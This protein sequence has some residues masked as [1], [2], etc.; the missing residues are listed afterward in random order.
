MA[1]AENSIGLISLIIKL[2]AVRIGAPALTE[3]VMQCLQRMFEKLCIGQFSE[4]WRLVNESP[5]V[6]RCQILFQGFLLG[7]S[8]WEFIF[9]PGIEPR[10]WPW[11]CRL[12]LVCTAVMYLVT[13]GLLIREGIDLFWAWK[14]SS[15]QNDQE[16]I[17]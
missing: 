8:L 3:P 6:V 1:I 12:V 4:A 7:H 10:A 14:R 13:F 17:I 9:G 5:E 11:V 2:L 16:F 15:R